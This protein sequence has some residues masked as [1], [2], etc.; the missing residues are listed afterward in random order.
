MLLALPATAGAKTDVFELDVTHDATG[1]DHAVVVTVTSPAQTGPQT[2]N[3]FLR[4]DL[5]ADL[6]PQ[7]GGSGI[8]VHLEPIDPQT[9][10]AVIALPSAGEWV[11]LP[12]ADLGASGFSPLKSSD[13]YPIVSF[14]IPWAGTT[15]RIRASSASSP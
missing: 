12:F 7:A 10:S 14:T 15:T 13:E 6:R 8:Q 1:S 9:S 2:I 5:D 11:V 4:S 3:V